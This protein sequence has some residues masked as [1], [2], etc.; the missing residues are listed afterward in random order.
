MATEPDAS[1]LQRFRQ[2]DDGRPVVLFQLLRFAKGG[3]ERYLEYASAVQ[4]ILV[5]LG[6]QILYAGEA[7]PALIGEGWDGI[8]ITRYPTRGTYVDMLSDPEYLKIVPLRRAA[9]R[10]AMMV[11]TDD[12]PGR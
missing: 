12:W 3:R 1:E 11:P 5:R 9:L 7:G 4:R 6:A 8:V 10:E 2:G